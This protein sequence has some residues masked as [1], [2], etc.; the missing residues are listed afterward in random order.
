MRYV[1]PHEMQEIDRAA[2]EGLGIPGVVL[3]ENA[4]RAVYEAARQMLGPGPD[5]VTVL[6][7]RGNNGG[8]GFVMARY[9]TNNR[10]PPRVFLFGR[11]DDVRG[12]ARINLDILKRMKVEATEIVDEAGLQEHRKEIE[13]S[14][15]L[16]D[17]LL[18]TGLQGE[19]RGLL[20]EA[21]VL[22]N[23]SGVP[24]LAIDIPSG[25]D[26]ATGEV[27]G[28]AVK[29]HRTVTFQLPKKAYV[30]PASR[31]YS[32][33]LEVVDIGIPPMCWERSGLRS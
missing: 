8:D 14:D 18:G 12:D 7:G 13:R 32:G 24:I 10:I 27:L 15:L 29:A 33:H 20:R 3:M 26:G 6:C 11:T 30:N 19:V 28:V 25:L 2:I 1:L 4:G 21:I 9:L 17:G 22:M 5:S 16:V 23:Q 31:E